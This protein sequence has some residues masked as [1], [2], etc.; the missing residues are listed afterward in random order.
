METEPP[1][2]SPQPGPTQEASSPSTNRRK[3]GR[4][5][6]KPELFAQ[7]YTANDSAIAGSSKR[8][9]AG[10]DDEEDIEE[11]A[12]ASE[13]DVDESADE[14]PDEEELREKRRAARKASSKK[15]TSE[16]KAKAK[17]RSAKKPK[18]AGN[19]IGSQLAFR[20]ATNGKKT[21]SSRPRK[22]MVRPSLAAGERGLYAEV[23]G[24]GR[25]ADTTAAE[26]LSRYQR[27]QSQALRD[28][29]NFVLR[30]TG[31]D[32]E[33]TQDHINDVDHAPDRVEDLQN[34]YQ[35]E[36]V[37]E[38]P[39]I[40]RAKK[41]RAFQPV[42]EE[43]FK[44]LIQTFHHSS[45]L[46]DDQ[47]LFENFE[48]WLSA[49]ST[50]HS[51]P[52]R[53]T[54]TVILLAVMCALCDVA[55]E[56]MTSVSTSRKQLETEKKK[57]SVNQGRA[58]A[59]EKAIEEGEKK[60]EIIDEYLKDGVN[61][62][63][64]HRYRDVDPNIR[65]ESMAALGQWI[66][67]YREYFFEGQFLR[68]FGWMLSD[69]V[70]QTRL[71]VVN[72]L[73]SLYE[74]K[75]NIAGMRSFTA[76]FRQRMVEMAA[77]DADIAVRASAIELV[78]LIRE[79]GLIEPSDIDTVG[80]L[81]FDSEPRI[82]K[83][84]GRFFVANVQDVFDSTIEEVR[85]EINEMFGEEDEDDFESPKGSWIKFKCLV[86]TLQSYDELENEYK[87]D[88]PTSAS[89]DALSGTPVNTRFVL[90]TEAIYPYLKELS[91]WQSLAGYLLYDHSQIEDSSSED[92]T[93]GSI[94]NLYK[95][96]E[97]Q[98]VILL[99]VLC[100][101]VKLRVLEVAKSDIDKRG[102]K[103][104]ALT[105][106]IP[107]I[108]E[109][110]AHNLA[111][112]IPQLLNKF[113]SVP[114][115]ASAVLRLEHLVD[116]DKIQD[117]QKDATA[118]TSLLN[119]INKQFLTHSD[120]DVLT[121]ASVAFLHAK[122]SDDMREALDNKISEL[123]EGMIDTL[124]TLARK[125]EVLEGRSIP[126]ST[127]NQLTN[128]VMRISNLASVTDCTQIL[129]ATPPSRSKGKNKDTAEIPFNILLHLVERGLRE[130]EDDE[131]SAKAETE[132]V[133]SSI[134][135]LLFYFM[136][137]VQSLTTAL[138]TGKASFDTEYFEVLTKSRELFVST[139]VA[140]MKARSGLDDIRFSATA[141][142][143]DLQT[144]FGTLRHAGLKASND[145]DV[146]LQT[147]G[148]VHE[149]AGEASKLIAK[150]HSVA[151]R[152]YAKRLR[153][154]Y[155][156]ADDDEPISDSEEEKDPDDENDSGSEAEMIATERLRSRIVAEQRLCELTG[157][158]VLAI[159]GRVI[160]ASG[161]ERGQLKQ[162]LVKHKH[163][164]GQNYR[165]VVAFLDE[166][167]PKNPR[168][169]GKQLPTSSEPNRN[170]SSSSKRQGN[171]KSAERVDDDDDDDEE[172]E[173]IGEVHLDLEEDEDED[174]RARGLVED[175]NIE[176]DHDE[177][178][179]ENH[180]AADPDDDE[181]MGD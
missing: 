25:N 136:W 149:I 10:G 86:D 53:H 179:D 84:A 141:T 50:S 166:R 40:S 4:V 87:P 64:V 7:S 26:W 131:E 34:E 164:L 31:T 145:E 176:Q 118:Y 96:Q 180:A 21:V 152:T 68:Y 17:P 82:R 171:A 101:A 148:L 89:K 51:R 117:L 5:T 130:T 169:K 37:G 3:S 48:I 80:R 102:R 174:L 57:K 19:G 35:Q 162:R 155:E 78:D 32:L 154:S 146:I 161:E 69:T 2:S 119:D 111:Q 91:Q 158:I 173:E 108:Q 177:E 98:E 1:L 47:N 175:E 61:V 147:Q 72:Q 124:S 76:R 103:V 28:M 153:F 93:S 81:V 85:D 94:K 66:R 77:R 106:K 24:K 58:S 13:P 60:L 41:F 49:M 74:N 27:E 135:T 92:D 46:Y 150:I 109:E 23:F 52:F 100:S 163:D 54:S 178:E 114:E 88:Q 43:F 107:E 104:K 29:V 170:Q 59:I 65:A 125:K 132:L 14:E 157:K 105:D 129:E 9:R 70:A 55:R 128:T 45:V 140:I 8:K 122:S 159:V 42:L 110:I 137:K 12:D 11:A 139:L 127:L 112:I 156:P 75:D 6:R 181:V 18:V 134:R 15:A 56:L 165:E 95:M 39:L 22:P 115:A 16:P 142:L 121:E 67:S 30:C 116:L 44:S 79:A 20:P 172:E 71:I 113:G 160:D 138:S 62:V 126:D 151:E 167:K 99:E 120:Q 168:P 36:G 144:L 83:A 73:R 38:W 133:S 90:V 33:V 123:W 63:F 97:G 143:L